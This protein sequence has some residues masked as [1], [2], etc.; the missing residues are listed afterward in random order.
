MQDLLRVLGAEETR[1]ILDLCL[2]ADGS[3]TS[4]AEQPTHP[5]NHIRNVWRT[6]KTPKG[7]Q[8]PH[9]AV[10]STSWTFL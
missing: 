4:W 8:L 9:S 10:P 3:F 7:H 5:P 1:M 6:L 2:W